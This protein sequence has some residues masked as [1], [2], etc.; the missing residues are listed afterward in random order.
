MDKLFQVAIRTGR[1]AGNRIE[2][3]LNINAIHKFDAPMLFN[4]EIW[5]VRTAVKEFAKP[6]LY[7][8]RIYTLEIADIEEAPVK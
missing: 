8:D 1:R 3:A 5:R 6:E 7:G 4:G 2:D